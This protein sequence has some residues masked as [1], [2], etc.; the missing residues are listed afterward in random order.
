[1]SIHKCPRCKDH[2]NLSIKKKYNEDT[3]FW[4]C[5]NYYIN[6]CRYT[7]SATDIEVT[8]EYIPFKEREAIGQEFKRLFEDDPDFENYD[9][10][11]F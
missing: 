1:M 11:K 2:P 5:P 4:A 10:D 3:F 6:G 8:E 7:E 9:F